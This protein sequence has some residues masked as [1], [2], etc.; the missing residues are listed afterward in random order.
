MRMV[1][2]TARLGAWPSARARPPPPAWGSGGR[3]AAGFG[4][5]PKL[6]P[7]GWAKAAPGVLAACAVYGAGSAL[8]ASLQ[9]LPVTAVPLSLMFGFALRN[10]KLPKPI[11]GV[12]HPDALA[13]GL[14]FVKSYALPVGIACVGAKLSLAD[15]TGSGAAGVPVVAAAMSA[16]LFGIPL[17]ARAMKIPPRLGSLV[18]VGTSVCGVTAV[19]ALAPAIAA[20]EA[21]VALA[22][23][24]VML[25]GSLGMLAYPPLVRAVFGG[26]S[27]EHAS[28]QSGVV[29]GLGI[30]DTAQVMGASLAY[31]QAYGD[32]VASTTAVVTKMCRNAMLVGALPYL[33]ATHGATKGSAGRVALSKAVPPFVWAFLGM[34]A[35]RS[36]SDAL[37]GA[38]HDGLLPW[39]GGTVS[40]SCLGVAMAGLGLSTSASVL[41]G[42]GVRPLALG[43]AGALLV[44]AT[45]FAGA[46]ALV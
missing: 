43:F 32:S 34:A 25:W 22:V 42:A 12:L 35:L 39:L 40:P 17:V 36:A 20:T 38:R 18:A 46:R 45:A 19:M 2:R 6:S 28:R 7:D 21:E 4:S 10:A 3:G 14:N 41:R 11:R 31:E 13:P 30:H 27:D 9:P 16:G 44:G 1:W 24:N 33:V 37:G 5:A 8:A 23:A 15:V 29:L 26:G